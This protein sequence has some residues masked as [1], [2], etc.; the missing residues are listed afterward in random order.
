M[1]GMK[2]RV[3]ALI[4]GI[5]WATPAPAQ[6]PAAVDTAKIANLGGNFQSLSPGNQKIV[7]ALFGAQQPTAT[8]P[9]PLNLNQIAALNDKTGWGKAFK[10]MKSDGLID[11]KTLAQVVSGYEP[12][13]RPSTASSKG[14][15]DT[16]ALSTGNGRIVTANAGRG[17]TAGN[18]NHGHSVDDSIH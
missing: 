6:M 11:A 10:K 17:S 7:R 5:A 1:I 3:A 14:I 16:I 8:G 9:A 4:A 18:T 2:L 15:G 12:T 13:T